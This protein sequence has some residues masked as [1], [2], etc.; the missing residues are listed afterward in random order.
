[1]TQSFIARLYGNNFSK[2]KIGGKAN[3]YVVVFGGGEG[4]IYRLDRKD[5]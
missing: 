4:R 2:I 1:M 5:V 3:F